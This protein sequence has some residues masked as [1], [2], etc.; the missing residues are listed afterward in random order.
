L[1]SIG[2]LDLLIKATTKLMLNTSKDVIFISMRMTNA[3]AGGSGK[4][5]NSDTL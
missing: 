2:V 4:I 5:T 1:S 3:Q